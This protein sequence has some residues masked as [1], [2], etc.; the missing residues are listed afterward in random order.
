MEDSVS[1]EETK[2]LV[3]ELNKLIENNFKD[4]KN[5][6]ELK[7]AV[8]RIFKEAEKILKSHNFEQMKSKEIKHL[9]KNYIQMLD[10]HLKYFV[11]VMNYYSRI[12]KNIK[13][14][15][16]KDLYNIAWLYFSVTQYLYL[17]KDSQ[18]VDETKFLERLTMFNK[19]K[20]EYKLDEEDKDILKKAFTTC[21]SILKEHISNFFKEH[22]NYEGGF[23]KQLSEIEKEISNLN[24]MQKLFY[25]K[26]MKDLNFKDSKFKDFAK[27]LSKNPESE[28]NK[29]YKRKAI[30]KLKEMIENRNN[31][32]SEG[33][34]KARTNLN[35]IEKFFNALKSYSDYDLKNMVAAQILKGITSI[36]YLNNKINDM[37]KNV[38]LTKINLQDLLINNKKINKELV[39][40]ELKECNKYDNYISKHFPITMDSY[41]YYSDYKN[42]YRYFLIDEL[43]NNLKTE[44]ENLQNSYN[45]FQQLKK[46][47][48]DLTN[49]L[50]KK[51]SLSKNSLNKK[52]TKK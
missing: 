16:Y 51:I 43:Q 8:N 50:D 4:I 45:E 2:N 6:T 46:D 37:I 22:A 15:N 41:K 35:K 49:S 20:I 31:L 11:D 48:F 29:K 34:I 47:I 21:N 13:K 38:M 1:D 10:G 27:N 18:E 39:I 52:L 30:K 17:T 26:E 40:Q 32:S 19:N 36:K 24:E 44:S 7:D 9:I 23:K 12:Y 42:D 33:L 25:F 14:L 28:E 5:K 3:N